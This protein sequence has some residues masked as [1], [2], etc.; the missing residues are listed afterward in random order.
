[1]HLGS[2]KQKYGHFNFILVMINLA[3]SSS[4][5]SPLRKK[6][7]CPSFAWNRKP[8]V[9]PS[10]FQRITLF[11]ASVCMVGKGTDIYFY[12][13]I[14]KVMLVHGVGKIQ[15][16]KN[17]IQ[18][19]VSYAL[20]QTSSAYPSRSTSMSPTGSHALW[21]L[22]GLSPWAALAG[23]QRK[24]AA[25]VQGTLPARLPQTA[26][27]PQLQVIAPLKGAFPI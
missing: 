21:L 19:K 13:C 10:S 9:L 7:L 3:A 6:L 4:M 17:P 14:C 2:D 1:M 25:C 16:V 22:G 15:T 5:P 27:I 24:V 23:D 20:R 18:C 12:L 11:S 26:C 8:F